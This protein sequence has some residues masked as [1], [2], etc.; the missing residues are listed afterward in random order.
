M[1]NYTTHVCGIGLAYLA[2]SVNCSL[3]NICPIAAIFPIMAYRYRTKCTGYRV[4]DLYNRVVFL[5]GPPT[6]CYVAYT[7]IRHKIVFICGASYRYA[8]CVVITHKI[9]FM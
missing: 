8:I 6:N 4:F 5:Y 7:V 9:G 1:L 3:V 2:D